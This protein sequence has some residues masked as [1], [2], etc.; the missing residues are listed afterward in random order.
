[1][2]SQ[3]QITQRKVRVYVTVALFSL[4]AAAALFIVRFELERYLY[5]RPQEVLL[6]VALLGLG[7]LMLFL[8]LYLRG[9]VGISVIDRL[10]LPAAEQIDSTIELRTQM[11]AVR[12]ALES[13][14]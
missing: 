2:S 6:T 9:A 3:T 1:M 14:V 5:V 4:V 8:F 12:S 10:I 13:E 11:A 7:G